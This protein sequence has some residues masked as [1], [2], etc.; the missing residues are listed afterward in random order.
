MKNFTS[1]FNL[2]KFFV[3]NLSII[4]FKF[5]YWGYLFLIPYITLATTCGF[6]FVSFLNDQL[7]FKL[8][9]NSYLIIE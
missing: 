5:K 8:N 2:K 6:E 4:V 9:L 3:Y 7:V 1:L